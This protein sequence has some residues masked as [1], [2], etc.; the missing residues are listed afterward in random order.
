MTLPRASARRA[1]LLPGHAPATDREQS[2][3][4]ECYMHRPLWLA[5]NRFHTFTSGH[6]IGGHGLLPY[7]QKTQQWP[8]F[9][10]SVA[11]QLLQS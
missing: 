7:E 11:P 6:F 9:S 2:G 4:S 10:R 1:Y 3:Q 8:G 5:T